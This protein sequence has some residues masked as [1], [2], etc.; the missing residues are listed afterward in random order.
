MPADRDH[1]WAFGDYV[2]PAGAW[3]RELEATVQR[4]VSLEAMVAGNGGDQIVQSTGVRGP[5]MIF[6]EDRCPT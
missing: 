1:D 4:P 2:P 3:R 6:D 5:A